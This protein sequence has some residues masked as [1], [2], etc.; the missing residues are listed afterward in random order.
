MP[1]LPLGGRRDTAGD[2]SDLVDGASDGETWLLANQPGIAPGMDEGIFDARGAANKPTALPQPL[3]KQFAR[4]SLRHLVKHI[5]QEDR[6]VPDF[7]VAQ[8][9]DIVDQR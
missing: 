2:D 1:D 8:D 3:P 9:G 4:S 7:R 6:G 5:E